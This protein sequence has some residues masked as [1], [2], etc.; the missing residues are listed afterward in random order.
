MK[1]SFAGAFGNVVAIGEL[2]FWGNATP[3][4]EK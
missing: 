4:A 3:A 1:M 2:N